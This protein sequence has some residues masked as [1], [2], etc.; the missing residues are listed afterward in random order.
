MEYKKLEDLKNDSENNMKNATSS[1]MRFEK[2]FGLF[3]VTAH[4]V[5]A[6]EEVLTSYIQ[7]ASRK[8]FADAKRLL[9]IEWKADFPEYFLTPRHDT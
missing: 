9:W 6:G 7:G 2:E 1:P 5:M 8:S 3:I 4:N